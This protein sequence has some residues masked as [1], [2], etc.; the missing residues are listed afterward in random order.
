MLFC[1][2]IIMLVN[3]VRSLPVSFL[4]QEEAKKSNLKV[5]TKAERTK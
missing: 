4:L 3:G 2:N 5:Y 1:L